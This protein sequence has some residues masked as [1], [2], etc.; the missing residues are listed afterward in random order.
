[1]PIKSYLTGK[2]IINLKR[3]IYDNGAAVESDLTT[4]HDHSHIGQIMPEEEY[5]VRSPEVPFVIPNHRG[6]WL[7]NKV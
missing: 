2:A 5:K 7:L 3:Q 4:G 1:M 6:A